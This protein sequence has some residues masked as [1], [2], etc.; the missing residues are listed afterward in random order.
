MKF[1]DRNFW[2]NGSSVVW[3]YGVQ[4]DLRTFK[5]SN[6][7]SLGTNDPYYSEKLSSKNGHF[8]KRKI[9][10]LKVHRKV[11][12]DFCKNLFLDFCKNLFLD[13]CK[14]LFFYGFLEKLN[15]SRRSTRPNF[16]GCSGHI[17]PAKNSITPD[18]FY[19]RMDLQIGII[20]LGSDFFK[21]PVPVRFLQKM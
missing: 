4:P 21:F 1:F 5:L 6:G 10:L 9:S 15:F 18:L 7:G 16:D 13:F 2:A 3:V 11:L 17:A 8:S 12:L 19:P 20:K 14:N